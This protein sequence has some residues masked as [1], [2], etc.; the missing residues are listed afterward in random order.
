M[1]VNSIRE[2]IIKHI[3]AA[4]E[5]ITRDDLPV[6]AKVARNKLGFDEL[7][8]VPAT[9]LP[10][11]AVTAGLPSGEP[12]FSTRNQ[13]IID[14][15]Q[16]ELVVSLTVYGQDNVTPDESIASLADDVWKAV[17]TDPSR[18]GLALQ[19]TIRPE[20][21]TG[22]FDPYYAFNMDVVVIYIHDRSSI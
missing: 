22:V 6:I 11:V 17:F 20:M 2:Q 16:S 3:V 14:K 5:A 21:E 15:F 4:L 13:A 9:Q 7:K 8:S 1:A 18:N 12:K 19:T 10:Y